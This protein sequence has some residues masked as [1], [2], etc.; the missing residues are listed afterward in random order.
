MITER[1][2]VFQR[3]RIRF[4]RNMVLYAIPESP[5]IIDHSF[6]EILATENWDM[7][8]K[9]RLNKLRARAN[10]NEA[11]S[12]ANKEDKLTTEQMAEEC[13]KV[14][15]EGRVYNSQRSIVGLFSK[16]DGIVL[17]RLVGT[18]LFK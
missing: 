12:R 2:L 9:H 5:D 15:R 3:I 16:F 13:K 6:K 18:A 7:I 14:I 10:I 4:A 1:A 11:S 17:E 8:L